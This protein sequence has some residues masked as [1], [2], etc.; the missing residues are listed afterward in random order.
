MCHDFSLIIA[1]VKAKQIQKI[2]LDTF[3][4]MFG[5]KYVNRRKSNCKIVYGQTSK[6]FVMNPG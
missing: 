2:M 6:N 5:R 3:A 4:A 1:I